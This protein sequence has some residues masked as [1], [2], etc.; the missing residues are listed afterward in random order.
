MLDATRTVERDLFEMVPAAQ[1]EVRGAIGEWS[2]KDVLA[3]LA[4]WRAIEARRLEARA[5]VEVPG[6]DS[7]PATNDP[8]DESNALLQ[9]RHADLTWEAVVAAAD[10]SVSALI[11]AVEGSST[12][13]LCECDDGSVVGIGANGVNHA[14]GHLPEVAE[15]GGG[16]ARFDAFTEQ[17]ETILRAG[18]LPP[19]DSGVV[20]YNIA[21]ARAVA[22]DLEDARRLL[23]AA[24][25]RRHD[26]LEV[27]REDPD[28]AA[29]GDEMA[30]LA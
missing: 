17:V 27:A 20:L 8:I 1:R 28:L 19:S 13:V 25:A 10:A 18:H 29:L 21:C 12:D 15:L 4:G 24:F 6:H 3:H 16:R 11:S 7:D 14:V 23:R 30:A 5:G 26:L 22:G 9:R 2:A